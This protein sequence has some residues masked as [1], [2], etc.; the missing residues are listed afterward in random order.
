LGFRYPSSDYVGLLTDSIDSLRKIL[1]L[2]LS[3]MLIPTESYGFKPSTSGLF[4][5]KNELVPL[6][7]AKGRKS[8]LKPV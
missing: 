8:L 2:P 6:F 3:N 1:M 4:T 7:A 5:F